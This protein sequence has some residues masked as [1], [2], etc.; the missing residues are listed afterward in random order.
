MAAEQVYVIKFI[1]EDCV[2]KR[3]TS[4]V[5][6]LRGIHSGK[7]VAP[8]KQPLNISEVRHLH[9]IMAPPLTKEVHQ[10]SSRANP[11]VNSFKRLGRIPAVVEYVAAGS[12]FK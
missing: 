5:T 8:P 7:E 2:L 3:L 6:E 11:F 1:E 12:R 4:A 9:I 10:S